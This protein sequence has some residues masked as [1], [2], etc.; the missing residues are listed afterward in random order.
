MNTESSDCL[1]DMPVPDFSQKV[2]CFTHTNM[3][4]YML[5]LFSV[6]EGKEFQKSGNSPYGL[7]EV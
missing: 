7:P 5:I 2:I 6:P 4:M 3:H 1:E